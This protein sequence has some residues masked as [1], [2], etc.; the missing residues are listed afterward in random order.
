MLTHARGRFERA[1]Y[2]SEDRTCARATSAAAQLAMIKRVC[3]AAVTILAAVTVFGAI[4]ALKFAIY[5]PG[6][7]HH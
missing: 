3:M 7:I 6:F 5:L 4:M 2:S 1:T